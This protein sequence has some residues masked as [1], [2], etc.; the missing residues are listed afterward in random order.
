MPPPHPLE[1]RRRAVALAREVDADGNRKHLVA[2]LARDLKIS[3]SCLR[4]WMAQDE[5]E[6]GE[7]PGLTKAEREELVRLRRENRVLKAE[8]DLQLSSRGLLRPGERPAAPAVT[9]S[10]IE[11]EKAT[12]PNLPIAWACRA[13][14]VS[15]G[16]FYDWRRTQAQPCRRRREDAELTE[17]IIAVHRQSRGTYGSPRVTPSCASASTSRWGASGLNG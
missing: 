12:D 10:F 7:R 6:T 11:A 5:V 13:F 2:A 17:T 15:T 14:G 4:N 16:G 3:E 8:R 9:F 1:F